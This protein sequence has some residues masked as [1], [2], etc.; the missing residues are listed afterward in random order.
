ME[1]E[2]I[3]AAGNK[4][5]GKAKEL[6]GEAFNDKS[7]ELKGHAQQAKADAQDAIGDAKDAVE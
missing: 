7:L 1:S 3:K 2:H 6:T 5:A 4:I